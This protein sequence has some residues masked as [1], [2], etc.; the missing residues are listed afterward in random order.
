MNSPRSW[1]FRILTIAGL[2]G[3]VYTWFQPW[4]TAYIEALRENG[5]TIFPYNMV[6]SGTLRDYPQWIVGAEM[7]TWFWPLMWV[8]LAVMIGLL[9]LSLFVSSADRVRLGKIDISLPQLL[10][11]LAGFAYIVYVVTFVVVVAIRAPQFYDVP[12]QGSIFIS[13]NEHT[14]SYVI[15]SLQSGYFTACAVAAVLFIL[16][17]LREKIVGKAELLAG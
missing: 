2:G 12:V 9:L 1:I 11:G 7:P 5:V 10:V 16:G 15:T 14:E 4:W 17:F 3:L 13:M 6:I 8:Y